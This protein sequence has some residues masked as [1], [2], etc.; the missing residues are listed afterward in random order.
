MDASQPVVQ[1]E[2]QTQFDL[3]FQLDYYY[4]YDRFTTLDV[5]AYKAPDGWTAEMLNDANP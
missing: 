3:V 1:R 2:G 5:A 4:V